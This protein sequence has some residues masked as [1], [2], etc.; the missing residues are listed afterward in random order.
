MTVFNKNNKTYTSIIFFAYISNYQE[1]E[2]RHVNII[3]VTTLNRNNSLFFILTSDVSLFTL[4]EWMLSLLLHKGT[5]L[6]H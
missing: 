2:R 3:Q 5:Q 1:N 4:L 6:R